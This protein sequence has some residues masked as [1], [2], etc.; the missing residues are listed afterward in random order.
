MTEAEWLTCGFSDPMLEF[1]RGRAGL[2]RKR[3]LLAV[4]CC[5][6]VWQWMPEGCRPAVEV[7]E[8]FAEAQSLL[9]K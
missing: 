8:R 2:G 4:G 5:R 1:L 9:G 7:T 6:R 3:R